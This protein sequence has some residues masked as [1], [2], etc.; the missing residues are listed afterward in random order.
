MLQESSTKQKKDMADHKFWSTQPVPKHDEEIKDI[1]PIEPSLPVDQVSKTPT[2]LPK[3]FEWCELD[4]RNEKEAKELYELL[5]LNY[6]EDDDAQFRFDYS[7]DFL[8]W[9]LQ[10]PGW[11]KDW[12][13][14][15]RVAANKKLVAFISAIPVQLRTFDKVT[16]MTEINF[17]NVHKKLRSKRLA[18]VM[19]REITRRS[20]LQGIFQ[21]VYTAG[22]ILPKPVSTCQYFHRSL[23]PKKLVECGFSRIPA[24][25]TLSRMIKNFKVP[26]KPL[27][28]GFRT[29]EK[30]DVPQVRE[31][32]NKYLN[33]YDFALTFETDEDVEHWILPHKDVVWGFVVED[34]TTKKITDVI[35]FYS[36]PSTVIGNEKHSTLNAA[37][38]FYYATDLGLKEK[39]GNNAEVGKRLNEL[40]GDG[41]I[42]AKHYGFDV[43]NALRLMDN[44]MVLQHQKFGAGDGFLNYYLYNWRCPDVSENKIGLVML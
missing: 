19:I 21:A 17:L 32:L 14:G 24:K 15:V 16:L 36:L 5:T 23:N 12:L 39:G 42:M 18:P 20:H 27:I 9:A 22:A 4:M 29:M 7:V 34:P 43:M 8:K 13:V 6:I 25:S 10:P 35:S 30:K 1:G 28:P 44:E 26:E 40:V 3:E 41:L 33:R 37:Y 38:L 11:R 2:P 31:L